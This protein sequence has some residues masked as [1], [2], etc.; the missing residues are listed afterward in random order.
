MVN[1]STKNL[2]SKILIPQKNEIEMLLQTV[3]EKLKSANTVS[4]IEKWLDDELLSL[5]C[6]ISNRAN[7][8]RGKIKEN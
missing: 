2:I 5:E 4:E 6:H 1:D 7:V 3:I 8:E